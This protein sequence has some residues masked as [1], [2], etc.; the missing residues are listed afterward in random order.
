MD[1]K[2]LT[3]AVLDF[4]DED[5]VSDLYA[6]AREIYENL[7]LSVQIFAR[8]T[9]ILHKMFD[10]TMVASQQNY[11]IP[12]DYV[13]PHMKD[14]RSKYIARYYDGANYSWVTMAS[15]EKLFRANYTTERSTPGRFAVIDKADKEDLIQ[16]TVDSDGA[17]SGGQCI[18]H[19]AS[20][21]FNTT[22]KVYP[23]DI[24]HNTTDGSDGYVLSVTDDTHLVVALFEGT[25][26]DFTNGD[27]YIIQPAA[28]KQI[29]LDAP[30]ESS[31]DVFTF[32]YVCLPTPVFSDYGFWR[33]SPRAC[34]AIA[35]GAAALFKM[36]KREFKE[37]DKIGGLFA[38]EVTRMRRETAQARIQG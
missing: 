1:G 26:D 18:L 20:M 12:P 7:D 38:A 24:I 11:D 37:S 14:T 33:I 36:P 10:I 21:L 29:F 23:R 27:S 28:E 35:A 22:N 6:G 3:Q 8:E 32:P 31:G 4:L 13:R 16:G 15:Y 19:D 34:K 2:K 25:D 30:S 17:K 5:T 9:G